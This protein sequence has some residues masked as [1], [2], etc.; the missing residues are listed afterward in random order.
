[1]SRE[2]PHLFGITCRCAAVWSGEDRMHC[3]GCHLTFDDIELFDAHRSDDRCLDPRTL[4][5]SS[6]K[7]HIWYRSLD[8]DRVGTCLP[9]S[10][11][12]VAIVDHRARRR[13]SGDG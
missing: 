9:R 4:G 3:G 11:A 7:N 8:A 5:L 6:T 12:A 10:P 2:Q 13:R 1:M